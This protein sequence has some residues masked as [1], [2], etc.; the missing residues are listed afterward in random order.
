[1]DM[2][3]AGANLATEGF[4]LGALPAERFA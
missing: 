1:M 3:D 4:G 2:L